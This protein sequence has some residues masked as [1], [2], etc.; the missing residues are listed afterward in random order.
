MSTK[1]ISIY[2]EQRNIIKNKIIGQAAYQKRLFMAD[3]N[4][5]GTEMVVCVGRR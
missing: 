4:S 1:E 2:K 3:L 5:L